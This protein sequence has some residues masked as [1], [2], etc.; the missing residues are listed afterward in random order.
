VTTAAKPIASR[1]A[2]WRTVGLSPKAVLAFCFPLVG[3]VIAAATDWIITGQFEVTAIRIALAGLGTSG[4]PLLG[5][6][7]GRPGTVEPA[8]SS[9]RPSGEAGQGLVEVGIFLCLV[10][11]GVGVLIYLT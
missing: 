2:R 8:A 5:A 6:Y 7:V 4:L 10:F 3:A 11:V 1:P 9:D